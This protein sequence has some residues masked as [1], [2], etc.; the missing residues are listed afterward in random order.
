VIYARCA[1]E[2]E[3]RL[4]EKAG[5]HAGPEVLPRREV[6]HM[7]LCC[8]LC[9]NNHE[10]ILLPLMNISVI[11]LSESRSRTARLAGGRP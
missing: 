11:S 9:H 6:N 8:Q 5:L 1:M 10:G 2:I 7:A 4:R 3:Q